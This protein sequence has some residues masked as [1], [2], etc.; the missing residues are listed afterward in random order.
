MT[1]EEKNGL[2]SNLFP[3]GAPSF[4]P[5]PSGLRRSLAIHQFIVKL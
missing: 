1:R 4:I 5:L 3:A 2:R